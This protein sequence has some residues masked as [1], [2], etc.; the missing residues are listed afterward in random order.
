[1]QRTRVM[2]RRAAGLRLAILGGVL[3][4]APGLVACAEPLGPERD[5][6]EAAERKWTENG[7]AHYAFDYRNSCFCA[8]MHLR[9]EVLNGEVVATEWGGS[10]ESDP[11]IELEGS[12]VEELFAR[13][14][15]ELAHEPARAA[16]EYHPV[17]GYPVRVFFDYE[18]NTSDEEWGFEVMDFTPDPLPSS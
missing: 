12:T 9:I 17:L 6:L 8:P 5:A 11:G 13:V 10:A 16:T 14:R 4:A 1:M 7:P 2:R 3:M 18:E 15:L